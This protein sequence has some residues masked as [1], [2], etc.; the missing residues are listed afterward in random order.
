MSTR[1]SQGWSRD[2][3]AWVHSNF[4]KYTVRSGYHQWCQSQTGT[5]RVQQSKAWSKIWNLQVSHKVKV[6][7]WRFC[8]NTIPV[9]NLL[10]GRGVPAPIGC[11]MRVGEVEHLLHLFFDCSFAK[12]CWQNVGLSFDM[13]DAKNAPEWLLHK[14]ASGSDE[15]LLKNVGKTCICEKF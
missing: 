7:L 6:L 11:T 8:R 10:R 13:W 3:I 14:P 2:R 15:V 5:V 9:R 1:I 4:G 12:E